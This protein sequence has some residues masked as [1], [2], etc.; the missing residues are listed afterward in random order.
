MDFQYEERQKNR[1]HMRT[2][3]HGGKSLEADPEARK[4]RLT[5]PAR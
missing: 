1:I 5:L 4:R 3:E 2:H